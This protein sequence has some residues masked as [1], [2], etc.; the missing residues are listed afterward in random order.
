MTATLFEQPP[1]GAVLPS[2]AALDPDQGSFETTPEEAATELAPTHEQL[3]AL[4]ARVEV[5]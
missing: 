2:A 3:T 5:V 4:R 1:A